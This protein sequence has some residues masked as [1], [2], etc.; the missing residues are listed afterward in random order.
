MTKLR[1]NEIRA[2]DT[3]FTTFHEDI[4][5]MSD[6]IHRLSNDKSTAHTKLKDSV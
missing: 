6:K 2:S 5:A 3:T 4:E 1:E